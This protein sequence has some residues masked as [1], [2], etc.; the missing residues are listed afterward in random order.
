MR[1]RTASTRRAIDRWKGRAKAHVRRTQLWSL[2]FAARL[3]TSRKRA[4]VALIPML[5]LALSINFAALELVVLVLL[6]FFVAKL[7]FY[8]LVNSAMNLFQFLSD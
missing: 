3:L 4:G 5:I 2:D 8:R 6:G 7:Q 1:I